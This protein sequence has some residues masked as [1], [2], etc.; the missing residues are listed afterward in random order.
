M[1]YLILGLLMLRRYTVY[2]IRGA[3]SQNFKSMCSDSMGSIQ[4]AIKKLLA[5]EMIVCSEY[6]EKSVNKKRYSITD[7]GREEFLSW[8][9]TPAD[10]SEGKNMEL[11]KLLFMGFVPASQR[12]ELIDEII[13]LLESKL[14]YMLGV[15]SCANVSAGKTEAA[16]YWER[17]PEYWLGVQKAIQNSDMG[18]TADIIGYFQMITLQH[19][20]DS[21]KFNIDWFKTLREKMKEEQIK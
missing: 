11:G 12:L 5:A 13:L 7:K 20:I 3:I 10:L 19:G 9:G 6:V 8:V 15:Q 18:E 4:T 17:D 14:S 2:E 16:Q 1:S 21:C